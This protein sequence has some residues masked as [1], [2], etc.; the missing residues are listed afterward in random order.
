MGTELIR[1]VGQ[2]SALY[3][4]VE[5]RALFLR[6]RAGSYYSYDPVHTLLQPDIS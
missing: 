2:N 1:D 3:N 5:I 6:E 4:L